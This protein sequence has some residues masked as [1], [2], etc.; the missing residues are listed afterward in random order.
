MKVIVL[1]CLFA[2]GGVTYAGD[3]VDTDYL[4]D[5]SDEECLVGET[6]TVQ[7]GFTN[8]RPHRGAPA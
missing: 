5:V 2:V 3:D 4:F 8:Q 7:V 6:A 1:V